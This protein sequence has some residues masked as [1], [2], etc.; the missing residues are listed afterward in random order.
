MAFFWLG[1][2]PAF[3]VTVNVLFE[4]FWVVSQTLFE[5]ALKVIRFS[6]SYNP[7][8]VRMRQCIDRK[9]KKHCCRHMVEQVVCVMN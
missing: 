1:S 2:H 4:F 8:P 3:H 6:I 7:A 5:M 9:A